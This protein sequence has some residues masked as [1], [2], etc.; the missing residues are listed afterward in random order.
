M[1]IVRPFLIL[2]IIIILAGC[3]FLI[4][5]RY[6]QSLEL[7]QGEGRLSLYRSTVIAELQRFSHLTHILARDP[8]VIAT[9]QGADTERLNRRLRDFVEKSELDFIYL[10]DTNGLT[11]SASNAGEPAS[12]IGQTYSFRP[13][14]KEA[15]AGG[16]G[17]FYGIGATTGLPGYFIATAVQDETGSVIGVIAIKMDLSELQSSWREAGENVL[18]VNQD[19]VVLLASTPAWR[20]RAL[21]PLSQAQRERITRSRQFSGKVLSPLDWQPLSDTRAQLSG[22]AYLHLISSDLPH[23]WSLHYFASDDRAVARSWLVSGILVIL[24][25]LVVMAMQL[26]RTRQIGAALV[27]SEQEEAQLRRANERLAVEIAERRAAERQLQKAQGELER[28][29]RL[30]A[31]GRLAALVTHELGQPIAAMRNHLAAAEMSSHAPSSLTGRIGELVNRMEGIT[32]QLKFFARTHEEE[33][34]TVDLHA[35]LETSL[36]LV[37]PNLTDHGVR[38]DFKE[39]DQPVCVRGNRLRLEQ[40]MTN[41]LRNA[42]DAVEDV[43]QPHITVLLGQTGKEAWFEIKDNGHGLGGV[44]LEALQEPFVTTRESGRGMGL[45]L[46]ISAG[47]VRDHDGQ[48]TARDAEPQGTIFRVTLPALADEEEDARGAAN[49]RE[50]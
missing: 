16:Q 19:G 1:R 26:Q 38:V 4:S 8:Y 43:E 18:L 39:P 20:Y 7:Q 12:F 15:M 10:M 24:A 32:R 30:A 48:M 42:V 17:R 5:L 41:L 31:L 44:S 34:E 49:G 22:R 47:I 33:F 28:A 21:T 6:F 46:A 50:T 36:G 25:G 40:T 14:F 2:T 35:A 29:S 13:Y 11:I 23:D 27:R 3:S 45:G 9:A 37:D